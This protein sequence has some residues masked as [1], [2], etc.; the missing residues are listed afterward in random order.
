[1]Q[2]LTLAVSLLV[3]AV[4]APPLVRSL[5]ENGFTRE[6]Y[7]H[8]S[9]AFPAGVAVPVAALLA[10]IPLSLVAELADADVFPAAAGSAVA[11]VVGVA[12]LGLLDDLVG[13]DMPAR[14]WRG[15][16]RAA[17]RGGLT[18]GA[19]KAAGSLGLALFVLHGAGRD[20][21]E[22]LLAAAVLVVATNL[23]NLLDLRPGRSVKA[24]VL[25]GAGLTV[26][27]LDVE[28]LWTV[29]LFAGPILILLPLDL[30]EVGMLGD[31]GSNA[32]GAVAGLWLVLTLSTA[33][34]AAALAVMAVVT[35]YGEFRSIAAVIDRTPGL[36]HL[37]SLGRIKHA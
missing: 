34:Q 22:Y 1:V 3:A 32:V 15:H 24:L 35:V 17:A 5:R 18:T 19:I 7:R 11:Y 29:G 23:F 21:G 36:R 13:S 16:A 33:G 2:W 25:L 26:G 20:A 37:D 27:S 31:T 10:L 6:N 28:P 30:R 14:G 9:V 8:A 12:L 4:V